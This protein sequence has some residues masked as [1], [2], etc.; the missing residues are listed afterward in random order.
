M[1]ILE[2]ATETQTNK[3]KELG[4]PQKNDFVSLSL[5]FGFFP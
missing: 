4:K 2:F 1:S 3:S 5:F